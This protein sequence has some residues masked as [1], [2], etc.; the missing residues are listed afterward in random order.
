MYTVSEELCIILEPDDIL[1]LIKEIMDDDAIYHLD[2]EIPEDFEGSFKKVEWH[3]DN[4]E[5]AV[6]LG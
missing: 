4:K 1:K 5:M 6:T 2:S 3:G